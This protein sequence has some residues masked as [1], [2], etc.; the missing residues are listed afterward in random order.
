VAP[1]RRRSG[2]RWWSPAGARHAAVDNRGRRWVRPEDGD[3]DVTRIDRRAVGVNRR[4]RGLGPPGQRAMQRRPR[5]ARLGLRFRC[6]TPGHTRVAQDAPRS[7]PSPSSPAIRSAFRA[8]SARFPPGRFQVSSGHVAGRLREG[9][10]F[11]VV[12]Q[13]S[14]ALRQPQPRHVRHR[15][16]RRRRDGARQCGGAS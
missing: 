8:P 2:A 7:D 4:K 14:A 6:P 16:S 10:L 9:T 11:T 12:A 15:A 1:A 13:A 5:Q 3:V